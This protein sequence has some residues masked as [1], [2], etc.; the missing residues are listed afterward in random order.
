[1]YD[2]VNFIQDIS[3]GSS[4]DELLL[5]KLNVI[6]ESLSSDVSLEDFKEQFVEDSG[7]SQ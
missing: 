6:K 7:E 5:A 3:N 4:E 2:L 1:M